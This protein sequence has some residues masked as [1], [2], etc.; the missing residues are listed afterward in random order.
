[1][2]FLQTNNIGAPFFNLAEEVY[3][4]LL[5][6][7]THVIH[8]A[9]PVNFNLSVKSFEKVHIAGVRRLIDFSSESARGAKIYYVSSL[10]SV[11]S[12]SGRVPEQIIQ[13]NSAPARMGYGESKF[14]SERLLD[15]ASASSNGRIFST[16]LRVGQIAGPVG[17]EQGVWNTQEWFPSILTSSNTLGVLP[18]TL[19]RMDRADWIPVNVLADIIVE[20]MVSEDKETRQNTQVYH[21][22]NPARATW[23][24]D[25]L[26]SVK[27]YLGIEKSV[28]LPEWVQLVSNGPEPD[29]LKMPNPA[30]KILGFY[31][32]LLSESNDEQLRFIPERGMTKSHTLRDLGPVKFDWL[33]KWLADLG[34]EDSQ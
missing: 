27:R 19:G 31:T 14:I 17:K 23:S 25:L 24:E 30:R 5:S 11:T 33:Q 32:S 4:S 29:N 34:F 1:V 26:P 28:A 15:A 13:D 3:E 21:L 12:M 10:S 2:E 7:V 6:E 18:N 20:I 22:L 8:N 16:V 9:W